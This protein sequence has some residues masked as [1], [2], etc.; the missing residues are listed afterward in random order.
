MKIVV[1]QRVDKGN[2][3]RVSIDIQWDGD[4]ENYKSRAI[5][6]KGL[7]KTDPPDHRSTSTRID[8]SSISNS[9]EDA[10]PLAVRLHPTDRLVLNAL[11]A[12]LP[13]GKRIT[14][15]VRLRELMGECGI[16]RSQARICLRRLAEKEIVKRVTEGVALGSHVGYRYELFRYVL[17]DG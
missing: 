6:G 17:R 12:R 5:Y 8:R 1:W 7:T 3:C 16:S 10:R 9:T 15:P 4:D 14:S 11:H 2:V 13:K